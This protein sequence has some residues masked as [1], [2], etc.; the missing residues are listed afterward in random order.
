LH[1]DYKHLFS[2]IQI[3]PVSLKNRIVFPAH[4]TNYAVH[5]LPTLR[6]AYYYG[7]RARGGAG[8]IITEEQSVHPSDLAYEKLIDAF[9]PEVIPGYRKIT[10]EVH[11]HGGKIFAQLNHNGQQGSSAF[12]RTPLWGPSS[13]PDPL[14]REIPKAMEREDI[15]EVI[16]GF[17][18]VAEHVKKG[19]F[20]GIEVQGS[21]SSLLRQFMSPLT[22]ERRDQYGGSFENRMRFPLEVLTA[23]RRVIGRHL[24]LGIRL[25]GDELVDGGLTLED[26]KKVASYLNRSKL[27]D[28]INISIANFHNLYMVEGSMHVP[29]GYS[30]YMSAGLKE[31]VDIPVFVAGRIN[32]PAQA[33][34][35]LAMG[36]ADCVSI[37][38]GQICDPEFA[39]KTLEGRQEEIRQCIACNQGCA[40]RVGLN[41]DLGCL[42]NPASGREEQYGEQMLTKP[43]RPKKVMVV[44]GGPAGLEAAKEAS[45]RGH[46]VT[47]YDR[48]DALGGQIKLLTKVPNR[49][50]FSDVIRNQTLEIKNFPL[51]I[52][53]GIEVTAELVEQEKPEVVIVA[54]GSEAGPCYFPGADQSH[55]M[56][57]YEVLVGQKVPGDRVLII[58]DIGSHQATSTAEYLST[59]NKKVIIMTAGLYVGPDL[60]PTMDLELWYRRAADQG[61]EMV[62]NSIVRSIGENSVTIFNHYNGQEEVLEGI[63]AVILVGHPKPR[64]EL[65]YLIKGKVPELYRIGDSLAP[66]RIE[67]AIYEGFKVGRMI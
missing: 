41:R 61:I 58:D 24:A 40:A 21:H 3:G 37:A 51:K 47:L 11:R 8:L 35:I 57:F 55:V 18:L 17:C 23:L 5:N 53:L 7:E 62:T 44:G 13:I 63:T 43:A 64:E 60:M 15:D 12:T 34:R 2:P 32:A 36:Q 26:M 29:L 22:N 9:K 59:L 65:Y 14:F 31:V 50:E 67:H 45:R 48:E 42:Q 54:T 66:R 33:E 46:Q 52:E 49:E 56:T 38:R 6:H 10:Y 20:D 27:I 1:V 39:K 30:T 28:F 16:R 4:L 25:S 19:G